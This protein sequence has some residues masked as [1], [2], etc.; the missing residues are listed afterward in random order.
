MASFVND[1]KTF[2]AV[3]LSLI[4]I[5]ELAYV[6]GEE[7]KS[8]NPQIDWKGVSGL[9][10]RLVHDYE[11]INHSLIWDIAKNQVPVLT[12]QLEQITVKE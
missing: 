4:Q 5:G 9:R 10:H 6:A 12:K 1:L 8:G 2:R 7:L 3:T 11:D